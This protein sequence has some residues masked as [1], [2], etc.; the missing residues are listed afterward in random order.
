[1][2]GRSGTQATRWGMG[3]DHMGADTAAPSILALLKAEASM[4]KDRR[5]LIEEDKGSEQ[6]VSSAG[7][8]LSM[9]DVQ[10]ARMR[11]PLKPA[12][13]AIIK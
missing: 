11:Y 4:G 8:I 5:M 6:E 1:M 12:R 7:D 3:A 13:M 10:E 9:E 2:G